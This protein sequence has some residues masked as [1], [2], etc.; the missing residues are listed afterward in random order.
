MRRVNRIRSTQYGLDANQMNCYKSSQQE[1][2]YLGSGN[3]QAQYQSVAE[4]QDLEVLEV[5]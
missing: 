3:Y 4:V 5:G 2:I 1:T